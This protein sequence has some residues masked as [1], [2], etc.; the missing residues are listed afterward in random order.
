MFCVVAIM[1]LVLDFV[2]FDVWEQQRLVENGEVMV[3]RLA[4]K[5]LCVNRAFVKYAKY[6]L[7]I[8][9][10][11]IGKAAKK[12]NGLYTKDFSKDMPYAKR[13][14]LSQCFVVDENKTGSKR[15]GTPNERFCEFIKT[16]W[17][18]A[19]VANLYAVLDAYMK[20]LLGHQTFGL[21]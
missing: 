7:E 12:V 20:T 2:I 9:Y 3:D 8:D 17:P 6:M 4:V 21:D 1:G 13:Y 5:N 10:A 18:M 15:Y 19:R 16:E 11:K 14:L